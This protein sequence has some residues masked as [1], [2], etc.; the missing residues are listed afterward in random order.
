MHSISGLRPRVPWET[1]FIGDN[2]VACEDRSF[3]RDSRRAEEVRDER[4]LCSDGVSFPIL[5]LTQTSSTRPQAH[6]GW[7]LVDRAAFA[8]LPQTQSYMIPL[9]IRA[10]NSLQGVV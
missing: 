1:I 3:L 6:R 9:E 7:T 10:T 5:A 4:S 8:L 2:S